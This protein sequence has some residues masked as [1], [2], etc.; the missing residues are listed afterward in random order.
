MKFKKA[1]FYLKA[2][3]MFN[4]IKKLQQLGTFLCNFHNFKILHKS[5]NIQVNGDQKFLIGTKT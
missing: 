2:T 5:E 1:F 4:C 3:Y